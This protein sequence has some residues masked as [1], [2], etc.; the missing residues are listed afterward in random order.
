[1]D[2]EERTIHTIPEERDLLQHP[3]GA[4]IFKIERL[5]NGHLKTPIA[6]DVEWLYAQDPPSEPSWDVPCTKDHDDTPRF[7][8]EFGS[9]SLADGFKY[10]RK[11]ETLIEDE[12]PGRD[13]NGNVDSAYQ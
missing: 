2:K 4:P 13:A 12:G 11:W 9:W 8:S 7:G 10:E 3:S 1:M 6:P 5:E